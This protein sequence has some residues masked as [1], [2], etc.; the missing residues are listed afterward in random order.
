MNRAALQRAAVR[1]LTDA[2]AAPLSADETR[3]IVVEEACRLTD[4]ASAALCLLADDRR[5]LDFVAAAGENA[6]QI[7]GLRIKVAD[8]LSDPV[9]ASGQPIL[10][11]GRSAAEI[12]DL[13]AEA[14]PA[15]AGTMKRTSG[16]LQGAESTAGARSAAVVPIFQDARLI[17]TLSALNKQESDAGNGS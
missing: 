7:V 17:G 10:L 11:D 13:F 5:M 12:G 8:S 16:R 14:D 4:A 1:R 6:E 2:L 15:Q 9:V 3:Q